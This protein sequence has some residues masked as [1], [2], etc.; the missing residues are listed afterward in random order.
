MIAYLELVWI[1]RIIQNRLS[2]GE[3]CGRVRAVLLESKEFGRV[4]KVNSV[5]KAENIGSEVALEERPGDRARGRNEQTGTQIVIMKYYECLIVIFK[6]LFL[7]LKYSLF[8]N[9]H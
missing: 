9:F 7:H 1:K 2:T 5:A 4:Q 3:T 8:Y 6:I